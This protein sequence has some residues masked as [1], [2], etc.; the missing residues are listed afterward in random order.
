[1]ISI[2]NKIKNLALLLVCAMAV[3]SSCN[4]D[5]EQFIEPPVPGVSSN[6]ALG[7]TLGTSARADDSLYYRLIVKAGLLS[8]LNNKATTYTLFVPTNAAMRSFI[9]AISGGAVPIGAPDAVFSGFITA[10]IP[11]ATAASIV[12]YNAV[13]QA[14]NFTTIPGTFPNFQYPSILNPAPQLS[15]LLRLTTF[16]SNRNANYVNNVPVISAGVNAANG[17]IYEVAALVVP[18]SAYLWNRIEADLELS[19]FEAAILRA[20]ADPSAPG[21]LQAALLNIGANLTVFAPVDAAVQ[22]V[23]FG[24]LYQ[25]ILPLVIQQLVA[26]GMTPAD[27]AINAPPVASAQ[28]TGLASTPAGFNSLPIQTVKGIVV[29]HI[30][31]QRAFSNNFPTTPTSFPTLLN[32]AIPTHAGVSLVSTFTGPVVTGATVKGAVNATAS[33]ITINPF[34]NGTSDQHYL[35]GV[36]HKIDQVLIPIPF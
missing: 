12:M 24:A 29:Y 32:G 1:M 30:L 7:D 20:D 4:K 16:P 5:V 23:L 21:V 26:G 10:N 34:P 33:N 28:A 13:P 27:A 19:Y 11:A 35:N 31:A 22:P 3:L 25:G 2:S 8:T 17:T 36:I 15:A 14:V 6:K 9:N 18:P